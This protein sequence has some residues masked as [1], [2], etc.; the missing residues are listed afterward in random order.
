MIRQITITNFR[1]VNKQSFY[2]EEITTFVGKNDAGKSNILRALNLFFNN[3]TDSQEPFSFSSDFNINARVYKQ[4]AKEI[5]VELVLKLPRSYRKEGYPDT[6][7]WKKVWRENGLHRLSEVQQYCILNKGRV[8]KKQDFPSRSKIPNLL[9]NINF[10]YVPAIKDKDFFKE[11]QGQL[12]DVIAATT[13][14]GLRGSATSFEAEI[15][16]HVTELL[17]EIDKTFSGDNEIRMPQNLRNIFEA[18][19][20]NSDNIPLGRRGDGIKIRHI[21]MMLSFIGAKH[22]NSGKRLAIKPLIWGFE[23]PENNVEFATCFELNK[24]FIDAVR[25]HTQV[26]I[27]THSPAIYSLNN[28]SDLPGNIKTRTYYVSKKIN[29]NS[30]P[31]TKIDATDE[32]ELHGNIGFLQLLS[33]IIEKQRDEWLKK[34]K[35]YESVASELLKELEDNS[36]PRLFLEGRSD[37]LVIT[38][39]LQFFNLSESVFIDVPNEDNNCANAAVDR[40]VAFNLI[41]KHKANK[42]KGLILLDADAA[43]QKAKKAFNERALGAK[44][45]LCELIKPRK[46]I[47]DLKRKGYNI[48]AD[49]ESLFS[50]EIWELAFDKGWLVKI[51]NESEKLTDAK[52]KEL[53]NKN[54]LVHEYKSDLTDEECM[55]VDYRFDDKGKQKVSNYIMGMQDQEIIK[56]GLERSFNPVI[57]TIEKII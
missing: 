40:G 27:T 20:F 5:V 14:Q 18:L 48:S 1:S 46:S 47:I 52:L 28:S 6:V 12:Y 4:R 2:A 44:A 13:E 24:Q 16:S 37:K 25:K 26:F 7:Y 30:I 29:E 31:E 56:C 22:Q 8:T 51:E 23:E 55:Y 11:L 34:N 49:L 42:V 10:M 33:P 43:G 35:E 32:E 41:Q 21:P 38:R 3:H 39:L 45:V 17:T 36:K 19:E 9:S 57:Q 53:I 54:Q 50:F 15:K